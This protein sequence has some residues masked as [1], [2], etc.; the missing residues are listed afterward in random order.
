MYFSIF[1]ANVSIKLASTDVIQDLLRIATKGSYA[2]T[3]KHNAVIAIGKLATSHHRYVYLA[4]FILKRNSSSL[5]VE[6]ITML[7]LFEIQG[8]TKSLPSG[9]TVLVFN[10]LLIPLQQKECPWSPPFG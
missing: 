8:G 9:L 1:S 4:C 6:P 2:N 7:L 5:A 3:V 10:E